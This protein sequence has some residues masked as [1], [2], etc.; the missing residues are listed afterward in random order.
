MSD[1]I[2]FTPNV[3]KMELLISEVKQLPLDASLQ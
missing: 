2:A 1:G 3:Y